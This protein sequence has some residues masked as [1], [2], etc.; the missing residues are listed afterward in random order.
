M[1]LQCSTFP[2]PR[3]CDNMKALNK[4]RTPHKGTS[5]SKKIIFSL[6]AALL[7][8]ALGVFSKFLDCTPSS[9]MPKIVDDFD[10]R[11]F[12]GRIAIWAFIA[13]IISVF[14][15]T[16]LR[17]AI[18]T[19]CF[20]AGMLTG[21]CFYSYFV[22]GFM[23]DRS[24][25]MIWVTFAIISTLLA[26]L[27]WYAKG[28][29]TVSI[30]L[31][32]LIIAYFILQAFSFAGDFSYFGISYQGLEIILL[33]ASIAVLYKKPKQTIISVIA[34]IFISY[35]IVLLPF[36]IPFIQYLLYNF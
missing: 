24:Y 22:A 33:I 30:I 19:L 8:L 10:I 35:F 14:S 26:V 28:Y 34:A 13:L 15:K 1:F 11:N 36:S 12:F 18:N 7:G 3:V 29:G 9:A 23:P 5:L 16:P 21:Y 31:S 32:A 2:A 27:C 4:I 25:L 20:F 17:A 6:L